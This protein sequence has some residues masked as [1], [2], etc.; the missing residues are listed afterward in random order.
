[1]ASSLIGVAR[2]P[3]ATALLWGATTLPASAQSVDRKACPAWSPSM[4]FDC[5]HDYAEQTKMLQDM[6]AAYPG[7]TVLESAG[8]SYQKRDIWVLKI[9]DKSTGAPEDKPGI[10]VEGGV[11]SDEVTSVEATLATAHKL[12]TA[13]DPETLELLRT[14]TFY[15]VPNVIPD[16]GEL[17]HHSALRPDDSTQRPFDEDGDGLKDE[18]AP[19]DLNGDGQITQMRWIDATGPMALDERD[20][21]LLRPRKAGDKGP[22]YRTAF[23]GV[24]N[25]KDGKYNEDWLGGIDPNR[26][27]P[28]FWNAKEQKGAGYFAGS[29]SEIHALL[30]YNVE[31][32]NIGTAVHFHTSGGVILYPFGVPEVQMPASDMSLYK[33]LARQGLEVTGYNLGTTVIDWRWPNGTDDRKPDQVWRNA[34]GKIQVGTPRTDVSM[35]SYIPGSYPAY[36]GSMDTTYP[37]FGILAYAVELY[38]MAPDL[39]DDGQ[40][41]DVD[42]LL[43][44]DRKLGGA[45]FARWSKYQHPTLGEVEIGGWTKTGWNN[46][47]PP[48]LAAETKKGV[49]FAYVLAKSTPLLSVGEVKVTPFDGVYRVSAKVANLGQQPT[50][51]AIRKGQKGE[52]PVTAWIELPQGATLVTSKGRQPLGPLDGHAE[53]SIEWVVK[54]PAGAEIVVGAQHPRAGKTRKAVR[55]EP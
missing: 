43:Q 10:W 26:N 36:G 1:M 14:R 44:N 41:N 7:L 29:E 39:N 38:E 15:I 45:A 37:M 6:A 21:R 27:Y 30:N 31:H 2:L 20:P 42:R 34:K 32:P 23:E 4:T 46:P 51:L 25:D 54:A 9:T 24:D 8:K 52:L 53:K 40:V 16:T 50:E 3:L 19:E 33:D 55:L 5:Y 35:P 22:F 11:D 18:D 28:F 13:K 12:L 47:L 48:A 17:W 49:D